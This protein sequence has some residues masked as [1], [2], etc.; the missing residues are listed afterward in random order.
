MERILKTG[1]INKTKR[2]QRKDNNSTNMENNQIEKMIKEKMDARN[3][4]IH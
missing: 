3:D 4:M 1:W 2:C